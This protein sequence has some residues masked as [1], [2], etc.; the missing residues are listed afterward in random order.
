[1]SHTGV[2]ASIVEKRRIW[3]PMMSVLETSTARYPMRSR[4]FGISGF[5]LI[6]DIAC[7]IE[8]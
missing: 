7:G 5:R 6:A 2:P 1:M 4:I 3:T 8:Q